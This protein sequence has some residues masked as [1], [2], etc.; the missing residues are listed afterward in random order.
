MKQKL[1]LSRCGLCRACGEFVADAF[2]RDIRAVPPGAALPPSRLILQRDS[3]ET[4]VNLVN[5]EYGFNE[6]MSINLK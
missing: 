5:N 2:D 3:S 4:K 6:T 1:T